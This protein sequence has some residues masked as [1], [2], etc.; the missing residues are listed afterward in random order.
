[1]IF[2]TYNNI[3]SPLI[4]RGVKKTF[5]VSYGL[6]T[7]ILCLGLIL[8]FPLPTEAA[9]DQIISTVEISGNRRISEAAIFSR[10]KSRPGEAYRL[11]DTNADLKRIYEWGPFSSVQVE[12]EELSDGE[13]AIKFI[14][15][16]KPLVSKV[17][18]EG[19]REFDDDDLREEITTIEGE[20]LSETK[21]NQDI[22]AIYKLYEDDGYYKTS[23][24]YETKLNPDSGEAMVFINIDE[25]HEVRVKNIT[26]EGAREIDPDDIL[27]AMETHAQSL[28]SILHRGF[29]KKDEFG[30]DL[31]RIILYCRSQG[32]LDAK[33]LD[34]EK[35][36]INDGTG[37]D[38][39]I[40]IHE[41]MRY[42]AGKVRIAGNENFP[43]EDLEALLPL[44]TGD[45]FSP[46]VLRAE[47]KSLR[48]FYFSRGYIDVDIRPHTV[49]N[50]KTNQ[51]D[52]TYSIRENLI[53][54]INRIDITGNEITRDIVIRRELSVK[55]GEIFNGVK[56]QRSRERLQNLGFFQKVNIDP[57][58]TAEPGKKDL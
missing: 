49:L 13:I 44:K 6:I 35:T 41:G 9:R 15:E 38:I 53:S 8:T 21:L 47:S 26:I 23:I 50:P 45:V 29:F 17:I 22:T 27:D 16:E 40:N 48:D 3:Y 30:M 2:S 46:E 20:V 7:G 55:P 14:V 28:F 11:E 52:I 31:E 58:P 25:G 19:N 39:T 32:Y 54:Y 51:M 43:V 4:I 37:L 56:V 1:M 42:Y 24:N 57:I 5:T 10:I 36:I 18:F 12:S 33:I 34:T